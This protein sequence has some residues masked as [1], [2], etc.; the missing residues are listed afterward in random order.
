MVMGVV[1]HTAGPG[2]WDLGQTNVNVV[3]EYNTSHGNYLQLS[4]SYHRSYSD[5]HYYYGACTP[6]TNRGIMLDINFMNASK[7][8]GLVMN[9]HTVPV[10]LFQICSR[11]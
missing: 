11:I 1:G 6:S 9:C 4:G 10:C 8:T 5:H 3:L 7:C 2:T